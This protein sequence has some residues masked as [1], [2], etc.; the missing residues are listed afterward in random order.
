MMRCFWKGANKQDGIKG[1]V[2]S[3]VLSMVTRYSTI[4]MEDT[5]KHLLCFVQCQCYA[6][7]CRT[8]NTKKGLR[9]QI[10]YFIN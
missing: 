4:Q 3:D 7:F 2:K 10:P 8:I 9:Y 1:A 5:R 6:V